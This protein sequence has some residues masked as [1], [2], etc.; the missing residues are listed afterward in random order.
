MV[1]KKQRRDELLLQK[2]VLRIKELRSIH[3]HTQE[4][5]KEATGLNIPNLETGENF[6]NL[7]TL[8][9]ICS[10]YKLSLDNKRA[11][12]KIAFRRFFCHSERSRRHSRGISTVGRA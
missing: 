9:I 12:G 1:R 4:K 8:S 6:P 7:T 3:G 10:Y 5:L 11:G 2:I